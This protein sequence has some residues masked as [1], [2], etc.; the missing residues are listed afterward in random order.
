LQER[1]SAGKKNNI[2]LKTFQTGK[3][4]V[5]QKVK[6]T[7]NSAQFEGISIFISNNLMHFGCLSGQDFK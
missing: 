3:K 5:V 7:I 4:H 2:N 6:N 1:A